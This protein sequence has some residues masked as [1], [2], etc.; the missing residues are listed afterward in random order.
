MYEYDIRS[1]ETGQ[2]LH[3]VVADGF[4]VGDNGIVS[5]TSSEEHVRSTDFGGPPS[6]TRVR[7]IATTQVSSSTIITKRT[8]PKPALVVP[9]TEG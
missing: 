8:T 9:I 7:L 2:I 6:T 5:F 1:L 3:T 4:S